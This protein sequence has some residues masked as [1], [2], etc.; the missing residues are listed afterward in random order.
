MSILNMALTFGASMIEIWSCSDVVMVGEIQSVPNSVTYSFSKIHADII[1]YLF[2]S[3]C[4]ESHLM[5]N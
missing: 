3:F 2:N 1:L 5:H 4:K